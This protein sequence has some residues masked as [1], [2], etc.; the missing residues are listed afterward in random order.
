MTTQ[1]VCLS[2]VCLKELNNKENGGKVDY[3]WLE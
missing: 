2:K 1:S 3:H